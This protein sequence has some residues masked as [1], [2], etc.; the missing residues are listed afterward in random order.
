[1]PREIVLGYLDVKKKE[2]VINPHFSFDALSKE[3]MSFQATDTSGLHFTDYILD[4]Q[5]Q[6][7]N[8]SYKRK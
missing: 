3:N 4:E 6:M 1:M 2:L 5:Q 7:T 8:V